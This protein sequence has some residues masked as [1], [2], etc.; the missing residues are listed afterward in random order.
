M[1]VFSSSF[2]HSVG[3]WLKVLDNFFDGMEFKLK[4]DMESLFQNCLFYIFSLFC[5]IDSKRGNCYVRL[6]SPRILSLPIPQR[7]F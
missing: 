4:A 7:S 5:V 3:P 1:R 2:F 6:R